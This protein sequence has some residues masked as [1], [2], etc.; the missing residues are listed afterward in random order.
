VVNEG[1][2]GVGRREGRTV[3]GRDII[4]DAFIMVVDGYG[5]NL[6]T[7]FLANNKLV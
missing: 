3:G 2:V 6:F 1:L 7:S 4:I 5:E